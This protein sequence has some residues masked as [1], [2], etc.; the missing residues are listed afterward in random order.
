MPARDPLLADAASDGRDALRHGWWSALV[1]LA[2]SGGTLVCCA[3]PALLV[4]VGAGA[5]LAGLV[6]AV[7]ALVW[8][9]E[10]KVGVF[11]L[12][13]LLLLGAGVLQWRQRQAPCPLDPRL[14]RACM[15]LR[16]WSA[17]VYGLALGVYAIG[18]GFAFVAPALMG[19]E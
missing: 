9:S 18:A 3:L 12:A 7:P 17:S 6:S 13:G 16:R 4:A 11:A 1:A 2:A 10:F 14:G 5:A 19:V 8:I 15:R